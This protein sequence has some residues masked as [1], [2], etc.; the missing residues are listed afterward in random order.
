MKQTVKLQQAKVNLRADKLVQQQTTQ[1]NRTVKQKVQF[2]EA[3]EQLRA[4]K[5]VQQ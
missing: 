1:R 3:K 4:K 5:R 2:Q